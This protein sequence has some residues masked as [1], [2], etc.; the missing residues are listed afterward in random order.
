MESN[1]S[2]NTDYVLP[3]IPS[4]YSY[5][6]SLII[7]GI[8]GNLLIVVAFA[9]DKKLRRVTANIFIVHLAVVNLFAVITVTPLY[10]YVVVV[11]LNI[12]AKKFRDVVYPV[13]IAISLESLTMVTFNRY[14]LI[15]QSRKAYQRLCTGRA[16]PVVLI[17]LWVLT[18]SNGV[19]LWINF[20]TEEEEMVTRRNMMIYLI[21]NILPTLIIVPIIN[22]MTLRI[23][24][25]SRMRVA[26]ASSSVKKTP[27]TSA[28]VKCVSF[29]GE[30]SKQTIINDSEMSPQNGLRSFNDFQNDG[31]SKTDPS[32]EFK[33]NISGGNVE[34]PTNM[35]R[36][37]MRFDI[38]LPLQ[39]GHGPSKEVLD[40]ASSSNTFA[41]KTNPTPME[42]ALVTHAKESDGTGTDAQPSSVI[43]AEDPEIKENNSKKPNLI[44]L[45]KP[46]ILQVGRGELKLMRLM[47]A[48]LILLLISWV[49]ILIEIF[50]QFEITKPLYIMYFYVHLIPMFP[51]IVPY[52]YLW[53]NVHF[54]RVLMKRVRL[55]CTICCR[56]T[57][58][59]ADRQETTFY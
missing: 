46:K 52:I 32:D 20:S 31:E 15:R 41:T 44:H 49:P 39:Q 9:S 29:A 8:V 27:S 4:I 57:K 16:I 30:K 38:D 5:F 47:L 40:L 56:Y 34:N 13:T 50:R 6:I 48:M 12:A 35:I 3:N 54:Q 26:C 7:I 23:I 55:L 17:I 58:T 42:P 33:I 43:S 25:K 59:T 2:D 22:M 28:R 53:S 18:L 45:D 37:N 1:N 14:L 11:R 10:M 24:S 51:S 19:P 21:I 36:Q